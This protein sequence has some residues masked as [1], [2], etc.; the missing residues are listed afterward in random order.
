VST[1]PQPP[2]T[3]AVGGADALSPEPG[4]RK[5]GL[6]GFLASPAGIGLC[7][8]VLLSAAAL[9]F[10]D[11]VTGLFV[12]FIALAVVNGYWIGASR[13]AALLGG[14]LVAAVLTVPLGKAFE[15]VLGAVLNLTGLTS[16]LVSIALV[17]VINVLAVTVILQI[18]IG[19][20]HKRKP[21]WRRHD[22]L[23][24]AGLGLAEGALL[25][26][27]LIWSILSLEPIATSSLVM[28]D[29]PQRPGRSNLVSQ[30][31][32]AI[33]DV[34]RRSAV[35]R[36]ADATNPLTE[37][38]LITLL[39]DSLIVMNDPAAQEAF[40]SHPAI[41][42][43]RQ[44]PSVQRV[45]DM[46]TTDP[47]IAPI[48]ESG[49]E[50]TSNDLR[51]ILDSPTLLKI[52]DETDLVAELSPLT[53]EIQQ[54][55]EEALRGG[56]PVPGLADVFGDVQQTVADFADQLRSPHARRRIRA[57]NSLGGFGALAADAVPA[58]VRALDDP[59]AP[60]R[61]AAANALARIGAAAEPAIPRLTE[62]L[63]DPD[64]DVRA[65]AAAALQR[66]QPVKK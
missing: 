54:A 36:F 42:R 7:A 57:A 28:T 24:G 26:L 41:D 14:L 64:A 62:A 47:Q 65:A 40:V 45:M 9:I 37:I 39:E 12:V 4:P 46:L 10:G 56:S 22:R 38:R 20:L 43:I 60:V 30:R 48:L 17:A 3:C 1:Q 33:A 34:A 58:L 50:I 11:L 35:G 59:I 49:E 29:G 21:E 25:G 31:V 52:L 6:A 51:T 5:R 15:G 55:I 63:Q 61:A 27:L 16:R 44:R 66:I 23:V 2:K 53:G 18:V 32:A 19:R 8:L 13:I